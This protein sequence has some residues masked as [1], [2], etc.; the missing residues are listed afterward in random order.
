MSETTRISDAQIEDLRAE[1]RQLRLVTAGECSRLLTAAR[2]Y[3][4]AVNA[5]ADARLRCVLYAPKARRAK[6]KADRL[7]K[8]LVQVMAAEQDA[9]RAME[10]ACAGMPAGG[11]QAPS[12]CAESVGAAHGGEGG[13]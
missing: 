1:N 2:H 7:N 9:W 12:T 4:N 3:R 5:A 11:A 10:A 6:K 13:L 8:A